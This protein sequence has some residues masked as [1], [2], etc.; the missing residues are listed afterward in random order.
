[1]AA[2]GPSK[3][4]RTQREICVKEELKIAV[5]IALDRFRFEEKQKVVEF[6]SSFTSV[7]RAYVH[8]LCQN[9]GLKSKSKGNGSNRYLTVTKK[10]CQRHSLYQCLEALQQCFSTH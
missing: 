6:P 7:E 5:K 2:T 10:E 8:R 9:L 3:T 1:M 4:S